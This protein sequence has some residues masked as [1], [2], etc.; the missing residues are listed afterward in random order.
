MSANYGSYTE[1][2]VGRVFSGLGSGFG[3]AIGTVYIS[4]IA[5]KEIRGCMGTFYNINIMAGVAGSYWINYGSYIQIPS[6]NSWQWRATF[7]LQLIPALSLFIGWPFCPESPRYLM[8]KGRP[9]EAKQVMMELRK[10]PSD[11]PY[12]RE[13]YEELYAKVLAEQSYER[14]FKAFKTLAQYCASDRATRN[15]VVF[16]ILIQTF[17]IMCGGNS[18]TYYNPNILK[19]LGLKSE[20]Q[21]LFTGVYGIIKVSSVVIYAFLLADRFGRRPLLLIGATTCMLCTLYL[22]VFLGVANLAPGASATPASWVAIVAICIFAIG[23]FFP[24]DTSP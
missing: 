8:L 17:F 9:E 20:Q 15:R 7:V 1:L 5:P 2:I 11:H 3:M 24:Q 21:L 19:T 10:L 16:V 23:K 14:G 12:F 18:I 22:A 4:E 13:E 6:S